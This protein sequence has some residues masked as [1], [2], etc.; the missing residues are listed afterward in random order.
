MYEGVVYERAVVFCGPTVVRV[1]IVGYS[2]SYDLCLKVTG[3]GLGAGE[4]GASKMTVQYCSTVILL[5]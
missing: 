2:S 3:L 1:D 4:D 5:L